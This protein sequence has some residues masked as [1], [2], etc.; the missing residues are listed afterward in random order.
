MPSAQQPN[1]ARKRCG[2]R[3]TSLPKLA[4]AVQR[5]LMACLDTAVIRVSEMAFMACHGQR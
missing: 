1:L 5:M 2:Q 4:E 3:Q